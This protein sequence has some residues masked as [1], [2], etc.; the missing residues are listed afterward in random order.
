MSFLASL[1]GEEKDK[2]P[3]RAVL[4]VSDFPDVFLDEL[5]GLPP[6]REI[7]F[8]ID[9]YNGTE[10]ISIAPY[11][12]APLEL[13]EL[14]N[15][16]DQ[17]LNIGF[18]LLSTSP[19]GAPVFFVKKHHET[20][21]LCTDYRRL[22]RVTMKNKYP[23][24]WIDDLFDQLSGS[25]YYTKIDLRTGYHQLQIREENIPK[26]TFLTRY[27]HFE[28]T[29]MPFG[30][31][32]AA[33][34]FMDLMH[35]VFRPYLDKFFIVFIDDIL[36]Y[37]QSPEEH[38]SH[39]IIVLQNLREHKL[40]AKMSKCK[41]WM[42]E[43]KFLGHVVSEQ[44]AVIDL[45]K[46]EVVM[47]WEPPKNVTEV[48]SFLGL[49]GFYRRFVEGFSKLAMLMTR[50]TKKGEKFLWTPECELVFH[51]LNENLTTAPILIIPNSGEGYEVYTNAS[52]RGLG[53]VLMQGGKVVAYGSRQLK[54]HEQNYP[55]H[56]LEL[57]AVV[58]ALKLWRY[59]LY[60]EKFQVYSDHKSLKYISAQ[61]DLN[62]LQR[63]WVEYMKDYDFTLN[64]P[65][66]KA[67]VVCKCT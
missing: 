28:Y 35:R 18:I 13:K 3:K 39:L 27:G 58:F 11:R 40:Y 25:K 9:L 63:R 55:T 37:S 64:Y 32:N 67:N 62:P 16:L 12:M 46:I 8:K 59:Y 57:A 52:L 33:A 61:K 44:G 48:H 30:L 54:T 51:T 14:R 5:P 20:L 66:G 21:R 4:V 23:L 6:Q 7:E 26:T 15:Q 1:I 10:P 19:W 41:F 45:V 56:D 60:R 43:V 47:K 29:V 65:P 31:T 24:P 49:A 22:N 36:I 17:F 53:C 42:K 34:A 50:L 38:E 2:D